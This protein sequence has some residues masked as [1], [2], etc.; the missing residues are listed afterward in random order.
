MVHNQQVAMV[1]RSLRGA[2]PTVILAFLALH[3][4][5]CV[6]DL[7]EYTGCSDEKIRSAVEG[8]ADMGLLVKQIGGH[9]KPYYL[10][11]SDSFFREL[12]I[13]IPDSAD[14]GA[15]VVVKSIGDS[16]LLLLQQQQQ[17]TQSP[18]NPDSTLFLANLAACKEC[19]IIGGTGKEIAALEWVTPEYIK[20]IVQQAEGEQWDNPLGMAIHRMREGV[21]A[22]EVRE[23]GHPKS[24]KCVTCVMNDFYNRR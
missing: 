3:C 24:C 17:L 12:Q 4:A 2:Q 19:H 1:L 14:S 18:E 23:N 16:S 7:M 9:G 15:V 10:P 6:K 21:L 5:L 8:L 20:A 22:P 11:V 13:Q